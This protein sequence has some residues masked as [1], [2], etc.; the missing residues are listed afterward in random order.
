MDLRTPCG[1]TL[2]QENNHS[3]DQTGKVCQNIIRLKRCKSLFLILL[4][5]YITFIARNK[6]ITDYQLLL[7][8][9]ISYSYLHPA[10]LYRSNAFDVFLLCS[11]SSW[12]NDCCWNFDQQDGSSFEKGKTKAVCCC[13]YS[14]N[15]L[16]WGKHNIL[17]GLKPSW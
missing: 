8:F 9:L 7:L 16:P 15:S 12:C 13:D 3:D 4:A 14:K 5:P 10:R 2:S 17:L 1:H 6:S 11:A